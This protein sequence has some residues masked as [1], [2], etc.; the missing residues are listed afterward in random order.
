MTRDHLGPVYRADGVAGFGLGFEV[1]H[2]PARA[3]RYGE[4]GQWNWSGAYH[5]NYWVDPA[6][7]LVAVLMVQLLPATGSVLQDRFRTGVYQA[8]R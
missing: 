1:W 7:E 3:G 4:P 5:T 6:R 8:L 2:Q